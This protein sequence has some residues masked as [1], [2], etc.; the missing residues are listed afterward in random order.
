MT[1]LHTSQKTKYSRA[2]KAKLHSQLGGRCVRCGATEHLQ[3][4]CITSTGSEHHG[5][6]Y[7]SRL[8][9]YETQIA[10][11]NL[12]LLCPSCH[13]TKTLDEI[14]ARR[15][16]SAHVVCPKCGHTHPVS[17]QLR[18]KPAPPTDEKWQP[19]KWKFNGDD[20]YEALANQP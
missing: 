8:K 11:S 17:D 4:D 18:V 15:F 10:Q 5:F 16:H 14:A 6:N 9:F 3:F 1:L 12:Q 2:L 19:V 20:G 7:R 13:T